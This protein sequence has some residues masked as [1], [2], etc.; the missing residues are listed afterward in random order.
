[1]EQQTLAVGIFVSLAASATTAFVYFSR[2][3]QKQITPEEEIQ[4][5]KRD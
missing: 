1:M 5:K 4:Q 2:K 3:K